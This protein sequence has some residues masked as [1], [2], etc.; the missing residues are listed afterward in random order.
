MSF[1]SIIIASAGMTLAMAGPGD[2]HCPLCDTAE[3]LPT[4]E[5]KAYETASWPTHN[6]ERNLYSDNFQGKKMPVALGKETVISDGMSLEDTKG[7]VMIIDFWA[8]WCGPCI[9]AAPKLAD[10]QEKHEDDLIVVGVS[11]LREDQNTVESFIAEHKE[12]FL[13]LYDEDMQVFREF[14]STGIPLVLV[15]STDG[16]I[17]WMGNPHE[18]GFKAAVEK[19]IKADPLIQAKG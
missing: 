9:A 8:T 4:V 6:P 3:K 1:I 16:V 2:A 15:V 7:K 10:L 11:G 12:P 5:A 17:R 14:K 19:V 18:Q 13:Q